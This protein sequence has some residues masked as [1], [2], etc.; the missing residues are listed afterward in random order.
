MCWKERI[1]EG[2][3]LID[4]FR[5]TNPKP[6]ESETAGD[7][8]QDSAFYQAFQ[9]ILVPAQDTLQP[10]PGQFSLKLAGTAVGIDYMFLYFTKQLLP[11]Q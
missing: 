11:S 4:L 6:T 9:M 10:S 2:L 5:N 7:G 1:Q 8:V 3:V